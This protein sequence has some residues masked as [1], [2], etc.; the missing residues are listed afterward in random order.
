MCDSWKFVRNWTHAYTAGRCSNIPFFFLFS[1]IVKF[2]SQVLNITFITSCS[3]WSPFWDLT[4]VSLWLALVRPK[5]NVLVM[6]TISMFANKRRLRTIKSI[7]HT[8][9][10]SFPMWQW[11][12]DAL[13]LLWHWTFWNRI[14][15]SN[16]WPDLLP[17]QHRNGSRTTKPLFCN[18][19]VS[20][21]IW[22]LLNTC[23]LNW[24]G[25]VCMH[26][27]KKI[28]ELR[29]FCRRKW[30]NIPLKVS[31]TRLDITGTDS[32]LLFVVT[33]LTLR[34]LIVLKP[35]FYRKC[36]LHKTFGGE[37]KKNV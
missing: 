12:S 37:H 25:D 34:M 17:N 24:R 6:H 11:I 10:A 22:T 35:A 30:N 15:Q 5:P 26:K 3:L 27:F 28:K 7:W 31:A 32:G 29:L 14:F 2:E 20:L 4:K 16:P 13:G 18:K 21:W 36:T 19:H 33:N 23:G 9:C 8:T 1:L